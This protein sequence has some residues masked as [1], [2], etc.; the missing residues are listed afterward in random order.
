MGDLGLERHDV[1]A[2]GNC[3][4]H[5]FLKIQRSTSHLP[6]GKRPFARWQAPRSTSGAKHS[7]HDYALGQ[8]SY[9][10]RMVVGDYV[11]VRQWQRLMP[12]V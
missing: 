2:D 11:V 8:G 10:T 1:L 12:C 7:L 6:P 5:A 3:L 9:F 4:V